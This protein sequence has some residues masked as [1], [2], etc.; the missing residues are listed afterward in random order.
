M[1][2]RDLKSCTLQVGVECCVSEMTAGRQTDRPGFHLQ[3]SRFGVECHNRPPC[4][5]FLLHTWEAFLYF[6]ALGP[7]NP[8]GAFSTLSLVPTTVWCTIYRHYFLLF[9]SVHHR[10]ALKTLTTGP[11][12]RPVPNSPS[13]SKVRSPIPEDGSRSGFG[14][15]VFWLSVG[16]GESPK[17]NKKKTCSIY[18][19]TNSWRDNVF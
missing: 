10:F 6:P 12:K 11:L 9:N 15:F 5:L 1:R 4:R 18:D 8:T 2:R 13:S 19:S 17:K 16:D 3:Y 14:N 7:A